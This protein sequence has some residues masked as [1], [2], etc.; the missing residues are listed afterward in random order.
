MSGGTQLV[1]YLVILILLDTHVK[2]LV[3]SLLAQPCLHSNFIETNYLVDLP[4]DGASFTWF[5]D[6]EP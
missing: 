6:A 1:S 4:L 2:G 3:V 5:R